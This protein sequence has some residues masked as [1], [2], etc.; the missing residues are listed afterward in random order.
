MVSAMVDRRT[1]SNAIAVSS[2][3]EISGV[4]SALPEATVFEIVGSLCYVLFVVGEPAMSSR[5]LQDDTG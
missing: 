3:P 2:H 5:I 4:K 1:L